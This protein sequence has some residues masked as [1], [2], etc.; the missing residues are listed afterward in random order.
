[1]LKNIILILSII[2]II[3]IFIICYILYFNKQEKYEN[4][5]F[6]IKVDLPTNLIKVIN[7]KKYVIQFVDNMKLK[8]QNNSNIFIIK[9]SLITN[10]QQ[11][12]RG[13]MTACIK[14]LYNDKINMYIILSDETNI[15]ILPFSDVYIGYILKKTPKDWKIGY[16]CKVREP[17]RPGD[18]GQGLYSS[19]FLITKDDI[20]KL[21]PNIKN[22][23][24][25][26]LYIYPDRNNIIMDTENIENKFSIDKEEVNYYLYP[27]TKNIDFSGKFENTYAYTS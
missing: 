20:I 4:E 7:N 2:F 19:S 27:E 3:I 14:L 1:M 12:M 22:T 5:I 26:K 6:D 15:D 25:F 8:E 23:K 16:I 11:E 24:N 10:E 18:L 9:N 21:I 13:R 17:S